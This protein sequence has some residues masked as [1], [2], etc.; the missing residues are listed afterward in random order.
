MK[1]LTTESFILKSKN[2]HGDKYDYSTVEYTNSHSIVKIT[3]TVHGIFEQ[4]P[5]CHL[6][7]EGCRKCSD[8]LKFQKRRHNNNIFVDR[9]IKVHGDKYDY[10]IVRYK[11]ARTK[12]EIICPKH[13]VFTQTPPHHLN[14]VG[15][16]TCKS[17]KG[18]LLIEKIL[19]EENIKYKKQHTFSDCKN[20]KVLPFDFYLID[21]DTCVEYDG[22]QHFEPHYMYGGN[23]ALELLQKNDKI[24]T[25]YCVDNGINLI[26]INYKN[27]I[28]KTLIDK[29]MKVKIG[30]KIYDSNEEPVMLILDDTDKENIKNMDS[31]KYKFITHP[32]AMSVEDVK[33]WINK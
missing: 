1:K 7:G 14:G 29:I 22:K 19:L 13:G 10:S 21:Y 24:K 15:C 23:E 5:Y 26:R 9:A 4:K 12:V 27:K 11:N 3:C 31:D 2:I 30:D 17:S 20:I 32:K 6:N 33:E 18:E 28:K 8:E 25:K 16:P